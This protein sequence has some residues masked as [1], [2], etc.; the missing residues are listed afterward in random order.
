MNQ[1]EKNKIFI[2]VAK[3][4]AGMSHCC[5]KKVACVAVI[6]NRIAATGINGSCPGAPNCDQANA[7]RSREEH[8][9]WSILNEQHAEANM[10]AYAAKRGVR[11]EGAVIFCTLQPCADCLKLLAAAGLKKIFYAEEYDR[12]SPR[13]QEEISRF[14]AINGIALERII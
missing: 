3:M 14:C 10:I 13:F 2:G 6:D 8:H 7:G 9:Q 1:E 4:L 11:L 12:H 5:A